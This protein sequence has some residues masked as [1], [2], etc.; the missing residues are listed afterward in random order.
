[1]AAR[2]SV[3]LLLAVFLVGCRPATPPPSPADLTQVAQ[4]ST[5]AAT[6]VPI[7]PTSPPKEIAE[8]RDAPYQLGASNT[9]QTVQLTNGKFEQGTPGSDNYLSVVMT[10]FIALG[11]LNGDGTNEA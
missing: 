8:I 1:M 2:H 7:K 5:H 3:M 6:S 9:L 11:D 4:A 10:D